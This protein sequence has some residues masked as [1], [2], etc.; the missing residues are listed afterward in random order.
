VPTEAPLLPSNDLADPVGVRSTTGTTPT[1]KPPDLKG[2]P[3]PYLSKDELE[4]LRRMSDQNAG[5]FLRRGRR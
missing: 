3:A 2:V 1:P 5:L 4:R